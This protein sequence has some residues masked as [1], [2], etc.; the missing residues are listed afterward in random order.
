MDEKEPIA[1]IEVSSALTGGMRTTVRDMAEK[2]MAQQ[3][4]EKKEDAP[5]EKEEE[6]I[7]E[8]EE[9]AEEEQEEAEEEE[10]T[11]EEEEEETEEESEEEEEEEEG[12]EEKEEEEKGPKPKKPISLVVDGKKKEFPAG[13]KIVV[14]IDGKLVEMDAHKVLSEVSGRYVVD[15]EL[16]RAKRI[17]KDAEVSFEKTMEAAEKIKNIDKKLASALKEAMDPNADPFMAHTAIA[18]IMGVD[19]VQYDRQMI[20]RAVQLIGQ[21]YNDGWLENDARQKQYLELRQAKYYNSKK[22]REEKEK[23]EV[24]KVAPIQQRISTL[25]REKAISEEEWTEAEE[26]LSSEVRAGNLGKLKPEDTAIMVEHLRVARRSGEL[27]QEQI[28]DF[29]RKYGDSKFFEVQKIVTT[30]IREYDTSE[31]DLEELIKDAI[32]DVAGE[33]EDRSDARKLTKRV[34]K[35]QVVKKVKPKKKQNEV[36][37][38][39]Q[40]RE[41]YGS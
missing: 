38:F 10:E 26:I 6:Q 12:E 36:L 28:P 14:P 1:A 17:Q 4:A 34:S 11:S 32:S 9:E 13:T 30:A 7:E 15:R 2:I 3:G 31:E 39:K 29:R 24:E 27:I 21:M 19:P 8:V 37:S 41:R 25:K 18:E 40:M 16:S 23:Q 33:D 35:L 22:V 5:E 20:V